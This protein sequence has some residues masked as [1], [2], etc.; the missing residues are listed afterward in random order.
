MRLVTLLIIS[1]EFHLIITDGASMPVIHSLMSM[2]E[3][4]KI[5]VFFF[6]FIEYLVLKCNLKLSMNFTETHLYKNGV[7]NEVL[8]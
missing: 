3:K 7:K 1:F 8:E 6:L 2:S 5:R 4:T